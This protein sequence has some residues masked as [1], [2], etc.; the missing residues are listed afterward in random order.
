MFSSILTFCSANLLQAA[1]AASGQNLYASVA[2]LNTSFCSPLSP[3]QAT[4]AHAQPGASPY[5]PSGEGLYAEVAGDVVVGEAS[6]V[7]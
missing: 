6:N 3:S 2:R 7:T 1:E 4:I 5:N